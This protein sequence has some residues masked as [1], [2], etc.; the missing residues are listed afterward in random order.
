VNSNANDSKGGLQR[1]EFLRRTA[2]LSIPLMA[3]T[4]LT[5]ISLP[6]AA[7]TYVPPSRARGT[8]VL[9]VRNY[10]AVGDGVHDDTA[11]FQAAINAL[12]STGGTITVPAGTYLIDAVRSVKLRS[13]MLLSIDPLAKIVAKPNAADNYNVLLAD[14]IHDVEIAG[15]QVIGERDKHLGTTGESGHCIRVRGSSRVTIRDIRL[16]NGWGDG[17]C[18]GPKPVYQ[19]NY[20]YS[21]DVAV[22]NIVCTNNRRNGMSIGNVLGMKVYDSEF[23]YTNGT[24]PQCGIDIEPDADIDGTGHCYQ[25]WLEN[26]VMRKNARYGVNVWKRS[27]NLTI[28]KCTIEENGTCG[29]VTR[30]LSSANLSGNTICNNQSTGVFLQ[31]GTNDVDLSGCVSYNNYLKQGLVV[32]TPF[33]LTG[34]ATKIKKDLLLGTGTYNIRVGSNYYK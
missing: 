12:P 17:L 27:H 28:T 15:G 8:T 10:G 2:L 7:S 23:S 13:Y 14:N 11:A 31:D 9:S 26:C 24:A 20:I 33:Y 18:V 25:V 4:V 1:R 22:S 34:W 16:A 21:S 5:G 19:K 3:G 29:L 6:A 30:E 32:R